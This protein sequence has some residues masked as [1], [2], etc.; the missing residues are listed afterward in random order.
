MTLTNQESVVN[1]AFVLWYGN[2]RLNKDEIA[3]LGPNN[4]ADGIRWKLAEELNIT[5]PQIE[6]WDDFI[7]N[8]AEYRLTELW[9]SMRDE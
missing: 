3:M 8:F 5:G 1:K 7:D 6:E 9:E 4:V 2:L